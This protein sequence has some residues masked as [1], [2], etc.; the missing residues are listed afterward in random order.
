MAKQKKFAIFPIINIIILSLFGVITLYP[1]LNVVAKAFSSQGYVISGQVYLIPKGF[2]LDTISYVLSKPEFLNSFKISV[3][4]TIFG[5]LFAMFLTVLTAYPLSKPTLRGRKFFLGI[6]VFIMLFGA[7][8]VPNYIL[9]RSLHLTNTIWALI[10]SGAFSVFNL[11]IVKNYYESLPE[12]VEEAAR[13]DG[14]SNMKILFQIVLPM[15]LPVVA[16]VTLFYGV[17]YWNNYFAGVMY[18]TDPS[19]KSLQQYLYDLITLA[20]NTVDPTGVAVDG[21][22]NL[23]NITGEVVRSATIVVSTIP[24]LVL[25]PFLQKYFVK[26]VTIGSVKG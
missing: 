21:A 19:L 3:F 18:I 26:G 11:F 10:F 4:V 8:M 22:E 1:C 23:A 13:I 16:T 17:S 2:Q 5:T 20:M 9:Y 7:G 15:S 14:A 12:T 24:I 25:Y 6:F